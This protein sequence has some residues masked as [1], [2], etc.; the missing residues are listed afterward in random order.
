GSLISAGLKSSVN[1]NGAAMVAVDESAVA[2]ETA[3]IMAVRF[4]C[5]SFP[6][7]AQA[8]ECYSYSHKAQTKIPAPLTGNCFARRKAT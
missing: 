5:M 6:L 3:V 7:L 4:N 8:R 1:V 2:T